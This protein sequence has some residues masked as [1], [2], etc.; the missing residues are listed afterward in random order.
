MRKSMLKQEFSEF[1]T[2]DA[3]EFALTGVTSEVHNCPF[4][5]DNKYNELKKQYNALNKQN[6]EYFIQDQ[7]YKNS[8]KTLEKQKRVLQ[9]NQLT[10]QDKIQVLSIELENISN[11]LKHSER[12]NADFKTAK[13]DLQAKLDNHLDDSAFS[14]FTSTSEDV[15][16]R[17]VFHRF[18]KTDSMKAV[19]P[20]LTGDYTSLSDHTDLDESQMSYGIKSS[21]SCDPKY[22]HNDFVSCDDSDKSSVVNT[23]DFN[24]SD[25]SVKSSEHKTTDST[26]CVSTS[27]VKPVP[28]GNPKVKPVPTG[29]LK[30]TPV[31]TGKPKDTPVLLV[32]LENHIEKVY[33]GY[34]RT[35]LD[36]IHLHPD[37]NVADLLSKALDGPRVFNSPMLHLLRVEMVINSPWIM[38]IWEPKNW[39][40]LSKRLQVADFSRILFKNQSSRYV[41]PTGRVIVPTGRYIVL[42]GRVIVATD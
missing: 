37:A 22:V 27:S 20:P 9:R 1:R 13:K 31:S 21:T 15:E 38:P 5:C 6:N 26:S 2:G 25:S 42:T 32:V 10:P 14:V 7:A 33:N 4:G 41:V 8:L 11:L 28:T 30:V 18:A 40:V 19:P 16:G 12:I 3:G 36:L 24:S 29:K 17:P 35:I 34:P 39:L 23:N